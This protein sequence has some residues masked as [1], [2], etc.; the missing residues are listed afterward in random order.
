[1]KNPTG[2]LIRALKE[3]IKVENNISC[4]MSRDY[5]WTWVG[6]NWGKEKRNSLIERISDL[7]QG[8]N[9]YFTNGLECLFD[10]IKQ[11]SLEEVEALALET[12]ET[13]NN[14][15]P[16]DNISPQQVEYLQ[17]IMRGIGS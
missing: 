13:S 2:Y 16:Q 17:A 15:P 9:V 14:E 8:L 7:G 10:D 4:A 1:M 5:W 11:L 12:S 6:E 3:G